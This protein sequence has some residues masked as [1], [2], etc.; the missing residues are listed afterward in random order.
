LWWLK[1]TR[2]AKGEELFGVLPGKRLAETMSNWS[3]GTCTFMNETAT[4]ECQMCG[5]AKPEGAGEGGSEPGAPAA[6]A[7]PEEVK[8]DVWSCPACTFE[9][10]I[11][12]ATCEMCA[13]DRPS[14][15]LEKIQ[16]EKERIESEKLQEKERVESEKLQE[17]QQR[18]KEE[19]LK[20]ERAEKEAKKAEAARRKEEKE[21]AERQL[22]EQKE[23]ERKAR[24][25]AAR[26][27]RERMEAEM[28]F[29]EREKVRWAKAA[30]TA[31]RLEKEGKEDR[32]RAASNK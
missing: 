31:I 21:R 7:A 13:G 17:K 15:V 18:E 12:A 4:D 20:R 29:L 2:T 28:T 10:G 5:T 22:R 23:R 27:E 25:E 3:C 8:T 32:R 19:R 24:E 16:R 9:N 30:E 26:I 6:P 1:S 14:D 11:D